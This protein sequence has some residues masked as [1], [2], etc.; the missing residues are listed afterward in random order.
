M[1]NLLKYILILKYSYK[2]RQK[3]LQ[4]TLTHYKYYNYIAIC[5]NR[6]FT[7]TLQGA[8]ACRTL[9]SQ[10]SNSC[11]TE[12]YFGNFFILVNNAVCTEDKNCVA[13]YS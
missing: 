8:E 6:L 13:L 7:G 12:K 10:V 9:I 4:T 3:S 1:K 11:D 5:T 2:R